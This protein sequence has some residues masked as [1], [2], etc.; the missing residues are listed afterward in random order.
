MARWFLP[1]Q[2]IDPNNLTTVWEVGIPEWLYRIYQNK[3]NEKAIARI[4]L[5]K[6]VL[7]RGTVKLYRGWSREGKD[8]CL[9][10]EGYPERD[11]KSLTIST[12]APPNM[13]F[14]VFILPDGTIDEWTWRPLVAIENETEQIVGGINGELIWSKNPT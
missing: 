14:L 10:Y 3:G 11:Y 13:A 12:P 6:E 5:V 7:D 8:D 2:A 9:V 1:F 4:L